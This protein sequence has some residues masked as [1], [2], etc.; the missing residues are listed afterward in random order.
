[1]RFLP[2]SDLQFELRRLCVFIPCEL[3]VRGGRLPQLQRALFSWFP[4]SSAC[5]WNRR[6]YPQRLSWSLPGFGVCCS[7]AFLRASSPVCVFS[8]SSL[9]SS[10]SNLKDQFK[11][12]G[13]YR[14]IRTSK[15]KLAGSG[16]AIRLLLSR[17]HKTGSKGK[18]V[19]GFN[20]RSL[21]Q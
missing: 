18:L 6:S 7:A 15:G 17:W 19:P 13:L 16:C 5:S 8:S 9:C 3:F 2:G 1:M 11:G 10:K 21:R 4:L 14:N 20:D 12:S